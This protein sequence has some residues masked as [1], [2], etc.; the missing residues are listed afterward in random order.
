MTMNL[1]WAFNVGWLARVF[2]PPV[3]HIIIPS[4]SLSL[5][6][7]GFILILSDDLASH[8]TDKAD[9]V[10]KDFLDPRHLDNS[11]TYSPLPSVITDKLFMILLCIALISH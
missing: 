3:P 4:P 7:Q 5:S 11:H 2:S 1:K 6:E 9:T 8:I 10:G